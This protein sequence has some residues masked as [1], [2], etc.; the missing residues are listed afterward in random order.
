MNLV[1]CVVTEVLGNPE[2]KYSKWFV[3]VKYNSW[4]SISET[5]VMFDTE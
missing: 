3:N 2:F 5:E 1:D 4:G